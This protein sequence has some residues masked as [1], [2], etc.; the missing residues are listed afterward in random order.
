VPGPDRQ[1]WFAFSVALG[2]DIKV[3]MQI[4]PDI[5]NDH[6]TNLITI[7]KTGITTSKE[8]VSPF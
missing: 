4:Q 1:N 2:T 3:I 7:P 5:V 6:F 8:V